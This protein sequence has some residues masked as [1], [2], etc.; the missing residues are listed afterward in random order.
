[1]HCQAAVPASCRHAFALATYGLVASAASH[2]LLWLFTYW[3]VNV[4]ATVHYSV[5]QQLR[6]ATAVKVRPA[7]QRVGRGP[8]LSPACA[9]AAGGG[10]QPAPPSP[11]ALSR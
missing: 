5:V 1:M 3:N 2:L 8:A 4:D 6:D 10:M 7:G 9:A 11:P